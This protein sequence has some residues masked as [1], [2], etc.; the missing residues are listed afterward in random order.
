MGE[1][2]QGLRQ[3]L[4]PLLPPLLLALLLVVPDAAGP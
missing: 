2:E 1:P 3:L 4:L